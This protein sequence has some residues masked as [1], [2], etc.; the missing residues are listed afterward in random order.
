MALGIKGRM[1]ARGGTLLAALFTAAVIVAAG[2]ADSPAAT[3][4]DKVA[5]PSGSD[6]AAGSAAAPY[7]TAGKLVGSLQ[8]GQTGCLRA[9]VY[10]QNVAIER[11]GNAGSPITLSSY[12]GERA[13]LRGR[14]R[15]KDSANFVT[16][17]D[18]DLDGRNPAD[19]LP[20]PSVYGNDV[21]FRGNDVTNYHT[22]I[23]FLIGS[24]DYGRAVRVTIERNRIHD[25]GVLPA[26]NHHHGIYIEHA[27]NTQVVENWIYDNADR[28]VQ[29]F[30]D[31]QGAYIANN[32]IDGNGQGVSYARESANNVVEHNVISN[33]VLRWNIE[34]WEL[35]GAGNV[36][37]LN[38]VWTTRT[39]SYAREGGVMV[40]R[41]FT[42]LQNL[43]ADPRF[44]N[45]TAKDFRLAAGSPCAALLAGSGTPPPP[46]PQPGPAP[47]PSPQPAPQPQPSPQPQPAPQP[48]P[49]PGVDKPPVVEITGPS[50]GASFR[51]T[52][53]MSASA[54]DDKRVARVDFYVDS[55]LVG[56][57]ATAPYRETWRVRRLGYGPHTVTAKAYD[58][59]G[60]VDADA[61]SVRRVRGG[62][63][64]KYQGRGTKRKTRSRR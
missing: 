42:A 19:T 53:R 60:Q 49:G 10:E 2:V 56:R 59:A 1:F 34:D 61:V 21:V 20:S 26:Q 4:C 17:E 51:R 46:A 28:G 55:R 18:L 3:S 8:P 15:V 50:N 52:L 48:A 43:I 22:G 12:P 11:G 31:S 24:N 44:V 41:D 29:M 6:S 16:I 54:K 23:C 64:A 13:T 62:V 30:P 14:L 47:G 5:A 37:R 57:D 25:C 7:R 45:R 35:T 32:V 33:S 9:G 36:A 27:D 38:C 39:G 58:S 63:A 40:T